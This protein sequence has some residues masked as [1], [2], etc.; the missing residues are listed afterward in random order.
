MAFPLCP[1]RRSVEFHVPRE[2]SSGLVNNKKE[3]YEF[4]MQHIFDDT[5]TQQDIFEGIGKKVVEN[6]LEGFNGT[7]FGATI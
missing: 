6:V 3:L 4:K 1:D 7:I 2:V 5:A